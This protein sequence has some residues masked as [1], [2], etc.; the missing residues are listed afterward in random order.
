M[1]IAFLLP[2]NVA[3]LLCA[4]MLLILTSHSVKAQSMPAWEREAHSRIDQIRRENLKVIVLDQ[5]QTP[6]PRINVKITQR[7]HAMP[8]GMTV[9]PDQLPLDILA[10]QNLSAPL[11]RVFNSVNLGDIGRWDHLEPEMG[12]GD[13]GRIKY[14]LNWA[15]ELGMRVRYGSV[16]SANPNH[17]TEWVSILGRRDL[18]ASLELHQRQILNQ[19]GT[20]VSAVDLYGHA[21][22]HHFIE[23]QLSTVML[24]RMY[25]QA[26]AVCPQVPMAV[27]MD[28]VLNPMHVKQAVARMSE[29]KNAFVP[30]EQWSI[31]VHIPADV[32]PH[33]LQSGLDWLASLNV[34]IMVTNLSF[35][36][37]C[38]LGTVRTA[39]IMLYSHP[40]V[41][42]L[43]LALPSVDEVT[44]PAR[45]PLTDA[46]GQMTRAG[47]VVDEMFAET[48]IS[49]G[50]L[51]T[52]ARGSVMT[53]VFA[54]LYDLS[55]TLPD[56]QV[57]YTSVYVPDLPEG[58]GNKTVVISPLSVS[59]E[60]I[61]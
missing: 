42:G 58:Q 8:L 48:W 59:L 18:M 38:S 12:L 52:D 49:R 57:A 20:R 33:K 10:G 26:T 28:D 32:D 2:C 44:S 54:G 46:R 4:M 27:Q 30:V 11:F 60:P 37:D 50:E 17:Q 19:F 14:W 16:F 7:R 22:G 3:M 40:A 15:N 1:P 39:L 56:G 36:S 13:T 9:S 53:R 5:G 51:K 31:G 25:E 34:P 43:Y 35:A 29:L 61:N 21:L 41:K 6:L 45:L 23:Q 55:A 47:S 24:R